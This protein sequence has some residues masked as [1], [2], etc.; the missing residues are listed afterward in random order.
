MELR[1]HHV[2]ALG[3][4]LFD[5]VQGP[6]ATRTDGAFEVDEVLD[7]REV[8]GQRPTVRAPLDPLGLLGGLALLGGRTC[9]LDL[10]SLLKPEQELILRQ[11][12][13][14]AAEA[15]AL[16]GQDDLAQLPAL[17]AQCFARL[18]IV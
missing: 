13:D 12:L 15:V 2:E 17:G 4:V 10:L 16:H 18:G 9:S 5:Q 8:S 7:P 14:A 6:C 3:Y 1:R 11:A